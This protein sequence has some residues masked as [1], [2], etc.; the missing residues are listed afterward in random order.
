[1]TI[2]MIYNNPL[3]LYF[4]LFFVHFLSK[5]SRLISIYTSSFMKWQSAICVFPTQGYPFLFL[6]R[7]SVL[8]EGWLF[9]G[10]LYYLRGRVI[11]WGPFSI[12]CGFGAIFLPSRMTLSEHLSRGDTS[13]SVFPFGGKSDHRDKNI[14]VTKNNN[15]S[16]LIQS[17]CKHK[18]NVLDS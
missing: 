14:I 15:I 4:L 11:E 8:S 2:F 16:C 5:V 6:S 7:T 17:A 12:S 13:V 10:D 18:I 9:V 1:M 3:L